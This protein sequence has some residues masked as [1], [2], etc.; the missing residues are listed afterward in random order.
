MGEHVMAPQASAIAKTYILGLTAHKLYPVW[1]TLNVVALLVMFQSQTTIGM[2]SVLA[3]T[4]QEPVLVHG[5]HMAFGV[6][7]S[8]CP[9]HHYAPMTATVE[10]NAIHMGGAYVMMMNTAECTVILLSKTRI[11]PM[12]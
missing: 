8:M 10:E 5:Q 4:R 9:C 6:N 11:K 7:M 2:S 3:T 12:F 1:I